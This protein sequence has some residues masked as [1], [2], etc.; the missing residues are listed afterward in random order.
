MSKS[1]KK[2]KRFRRE[3]VPNITPTA[4]S[5]DLQNPDTLTFR[6]EPLR[7]L[8]KP[9]HDGN[10]VEQHT[11]FCETNFV[12]SPLQTQ[13]LQQIWEANIPIS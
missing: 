9:A 5:Q 2:P 7:F 4:V 12:V 13:H 11:N 1:L 10:V 6:A 8:Q 3:P